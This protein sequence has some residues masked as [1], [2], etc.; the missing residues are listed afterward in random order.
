MDGVLY[1]TAKKK[2]KRGGNQDMHELPK[3]KSMDA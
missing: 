1:Y 3:S 2:L